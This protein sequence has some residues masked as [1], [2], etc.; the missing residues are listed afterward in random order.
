MTVQRAVKAGAWSAIDVVLR[1]LLSFAITVALARLLLPEEFGIFA[2]MALFT[3]LSTVFLHGGLTAALIQRQDTSREQEST[4]F[5]LNLAAS[6]AFALLLLAIGP[7]VARFFGHAVLQPLLALAGA[8]I[9][10]SALGAVQA[11]LLTRE[12]KFGALTKAGV[13]STFGS[14]ALAVWAAVE[15][16][17][18]W[19]LA[20]QVTAMAGISSGA[21]WMLSGWRPLLKVNLREVSHLVGFGGPLILSSTIEVIFAQSFTVVIGKIFGVRDLGFFTRASGTQAL[22][23]GIL[24]NIIS[25]VALPL[26][27]GRKDEPEALQRGLRLS[28]SWATL[29]N[30]PMMVGLAILSDLVLLCLFGA[31]WVPAAPFLTILAVG[32]ILIPL[33]TL[34]IQLL[35]GLG[36]SKTFLKLGLQKVA[37]G[38]VALGIGA[39]WGLVGVCWALVIN[40]VLGLVINTAPIRKEIGYGFWQQLRDLKGIAFAGVVMGA[41]VWLAKPHLH[42]SP[43]INLALL[44]AFGALVYVATGLL[45]RSTSFREALDTLSTVVRER[46]GTKTKLV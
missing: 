8:Q 42:F 9:V 35:L 13:A 46:I 11:A 33:H 14:G 5:W 26:F 17:G 43:W 4:V 10:L 39:A 37:L 12:L 3:S 2:I 24:M 36:R 20:F 1:Q 34:N 18:V 31:K 23:S 30:L 40:S 32:G 45:S 27:A 6:I 16:A 29:A 19:A 41:A 25:R 22:P 38:F 21:L 7:F 15:G 44:S 28:Q